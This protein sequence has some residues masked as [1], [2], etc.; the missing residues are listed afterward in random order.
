MLAAPDIVVHPAALLQVGA[1]AE[2]ALARPRQHHGADIVAP[3]QFLAEE[4][5]HVLRGPC[6]EGVHRLRPVKRD[7]NHAVGALFR[8]ETARAHSRE[9]S[10]VVSPGMKI[11]RTP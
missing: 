10:Q 11:I 8:P 5:Q 6:V 4:R 3:P 1:D 9:G 2:G 7:Q